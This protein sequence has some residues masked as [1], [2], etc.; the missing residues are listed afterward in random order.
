MCHYP[1]KSIK[2][3]EAIETHAAWKSSVWCCSWKPFINI[4]IKKEKSE[5]VLSI[6][7]KM[8]QFLFILRGKWSLCVWCVHRTE[9][10]NIKQHYKIY[11]STRQYNITK[12]QLR[13]EKIN[14]LLVGLRKQQ[15]LFTH[16]WE[17]GEAAVKAIYLVFSKT[18]SGSKPC[19]D[20][21][22]EDVLAV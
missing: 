21:E 15:S 19:F 16:S 22:F 7:T 12:E 18:A 11:H 1:I 3:V 17:I 20:G 6:S 8:D 10:Y 5:R 9:K 14:E 4:F 2:L 13:T